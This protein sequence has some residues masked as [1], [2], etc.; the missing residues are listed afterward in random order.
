MKTAT[1][2]DDRPKIILLC[3]ALL[4][5]VVFISVTLISS[6]KEQEVAAAETDDVSLML[7]QATDNSGVML[8]WSVSRPV[9]RNPFQA[10]APGSRPA[11][12][13]PAEVVNLQVAVTPKAPTEVA[14]PVKPTLKKTIVLKGVVLNLSNNAFAPLAFLEIDGETS[15]FKVGRTLTGGVVLWSIG[16]DGVVID[17]YGVREVLGVKQSIG[18][19]RR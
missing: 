7:P 17:V 6:N 9:G 14:P 8:L 10:G 5:A 12:A 15:T 3:V 19:R 4:V 11:V 2:S 13:P 1:K 18:P 16:M